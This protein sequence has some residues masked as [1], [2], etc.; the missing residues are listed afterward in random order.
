MG[1]GIPIPRELQHS[2]ST[3]DLKEFLE[4]G[5]LLLWSH[6]PGRRPFVELSAMEVSTTAF[7]VQK[8]FT[9]YSSHDWSLID[10]CG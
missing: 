6:K 2:I 10:E 4:R 8:I 3:H 7:G 1:E 5:S 9:D